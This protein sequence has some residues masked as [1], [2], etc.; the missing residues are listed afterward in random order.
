MIRIVS[1]TGGGFFSLE[2]LSVKK[3]LDTL[4]SCDPDASITSI[5][6]NPLFRGR[7]VN[8]P[9]FLVAAL[10]GVLMKVIFAPT[11]SCTKFDAVLTL[12]FPVG[13]SDQDVTCGGNHT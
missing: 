12:N 4:Q 5:V 10:K 13:S 9:A 7:S 8:T 3:I 11:G 6:L 2:W 1:N